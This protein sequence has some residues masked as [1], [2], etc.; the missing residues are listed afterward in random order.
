[1]N[2]SASTAAGQRHFFSGLAA[3]T[4][5]LVFGWGLALAQMIDPRKVLGFLDLAGAWDA[6]LMLVLGGAV[7]VTAIGF[8]MVLRRQSPWFETQFR[9]PAAAAID[10]PLMLGSAIFGIGWGLAGYCPGPA[11]A[12]LAFA[13]VEALWFVPAM[14]AGAGLARW[15]VRRAA[16]QALLGARTA[17]QTLAAQTAGAGGEDG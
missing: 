9:V 11:I 15:Q 1:M 3:L 16:D 8:R 12:S 4:A 2:Q 5:G 17:V 6:S 7:A 10:P 14:V 13:N